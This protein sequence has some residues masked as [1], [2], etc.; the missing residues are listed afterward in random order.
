MSSPSRDRWGDEAGF[1]LLELILT[2]TLALTLTAIA[3]GVTPNIVRMAKGESGALELDAFLKRHREMAIARRRDIEIRFILPNQVESAV[4]AVPDPPNAT[5]AP[6]VLERLTFEGRIEY[7]K[8][9]DVP[10]TPDGFRN[11][12]AVQ[13][14]G[15]T[16]V[17]FSS[18]GAFLDVAGNPVNATLSLGVKGD[19]Q[20]ATAVTILGTTASIRRWR[21]NSTGWAR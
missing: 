3:V 4:R 6:E 20:T 11:D 10:D 5:P 13:L 14:G 17:M 2:I 12:N 15:N 1:S 8:P 21:W 18:D 7:W 16:P 9:D 19:P